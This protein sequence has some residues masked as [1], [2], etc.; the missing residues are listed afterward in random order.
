[1]ARSWSAPIAYRTAASRDRNIEYKTYMQ[2]VPYFDRLDYVSM[3]EVYLCAGGRGFWASP[4]LTAQWIRVL[5]A[6][7]RAF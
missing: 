5:F 2:A 1:M 3:C 6:K 4:H 7:S